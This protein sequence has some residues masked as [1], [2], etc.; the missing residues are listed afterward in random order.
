LTGGLLAAPLGAGGQS[1]GEV[2]KIGAISLGDPPKRGPDPNP[3]W[4]PMRTLGWVEGQN[5]TVERRGAGGDWNRVPLLAS[6]LVRLKVDVFLVLS[7]GVAQGVQQ[8]N[9]TI[10]IC[11]LGGDLQASGVVRDLAKPDGIVTG[12]QTS[13]ADLAGKR[14]ALLKEAVPQL[15][16]AGVLV[17]NSYYPTEAATVMKAREA[18]GP[19]GLQLHV[20]ELRSVNTAPERGT[21]QDPRPGDF[22][23]ALRTLT[24]ARVGGLL[25]T[26]T[27]A[28]SS[29]RS[30]ILSLVRKSRAVAI[31]ENHD[32]PDA[33]GLMSYGP[34]SSELWRGLAQCVDKMLRGLKPAEV[35]VQQPSQFELVINLK[36]AKALGLTIPP[37]LLLRADRVIE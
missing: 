1:K 17:P 19:L 18:A 29:H 25:V 14:L 3:F 10:P 35:P 33:G 20:V 24:S 31:Y 16:R 2:R 30:Q 9:W 22:E 5:V 11:V 34:V 28:M 13:K 32:W 23:R 15:T 36:T 12:V 21:A 7:E 26:S 37:S 27:P 6:E 4:E 8:A